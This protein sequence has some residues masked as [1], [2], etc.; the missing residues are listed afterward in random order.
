ME[1]VSSLDASWRLGTVCNCSSI[2]FVTADKRR[3][4][5]EKGPGSFYELILQRWDWPHL[6]AR[7]SL[8][9]QCNP[10]GSLPRASR[11]P[12]PLKLFPVLGKWRR[13]QGNQMTDSTLCLFYTYTVSPVLSFVLSFFLSFFLSFYL[14]FSL[15]SVSLSI[16][17]FLSLSLVSLDGSLSVYLSSLCVSLSL[18]VSFSL[19]SSFFFLPVF[20]FYL[21]V[22]LFLI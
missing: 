6:R 3:G 22:C 5:L 7:L 15:Y 4:S 2:V 18:S 8:L 10:I 16:L 14:S 17:F 1:R 9:L 19:C 12:S 20:L 21:S 13:D 11:L